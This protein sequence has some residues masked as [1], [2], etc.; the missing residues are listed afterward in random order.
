MDYNLKTS[1]LARFF[2]VFYRCG[3]VIFSTLSLPA[4]TSLEKPQRQYRRKRSKTL[5]EI[6][7]LIVR[8]PEGTVQDKHHPALA[9]CC[10]FLFEGLC[11]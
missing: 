3:F 10:V 9:V 4:E 8:G 1:Y 11:P 5:I 2:I 6:M 7:V